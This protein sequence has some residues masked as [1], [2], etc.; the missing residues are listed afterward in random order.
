M[1]PVRREVD[2]RSVG[3][4]QQRWVAWPVAWSAV[5]V[6]A[7]AALAAALVIGLIGLALG[8]HELVPPRRVV[9][10]RDF[11]LGAAVFSV[12]G[13]L[14]AFGAGGWVA[15]KIAGIR[16]TEPAMLHGAIV[17]LLAVPILLVVAA[18]GA[19]GYFGGWYGGLAGTPS[20]VTPPSGPIDPDAAMAARNS[21]LGAITALLL[22]LVGSVI[23]GWLGSRK[24]MASY[25]DRT[26]PVT[27]GRPVV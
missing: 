4:Y 16:R 2:E 9:R 26:P 11:G 22:G 3:L 7:L 19:G 20:W 1:D 10:V 21:A 18:M 27:A 12:V 25:D 24:P 15:C 17:W 23:G 8:A 5:W 13:A 6:G 14:L